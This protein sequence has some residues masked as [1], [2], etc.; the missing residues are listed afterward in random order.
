MNQENIRNEKQWRGTT[1]LI[2]EYKINWEKQLP[3]EMRLVGL[4]LRLE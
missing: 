2:D 1:T 4:S 3:R